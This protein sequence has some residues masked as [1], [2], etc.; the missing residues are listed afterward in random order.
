MFE[1]ALAPA[2]Q[3]TA[4]RDGGASSLHVLILTD[5]DWT[6]PQGGGTGTHL[7]AHVIRWLEWGHRVTIVACGY[8]GAVPYEEV[9]N[10]TIHRMGGRLTVFPRAIWKLCRGL[11]P[12]ADVTLEVINGISYLTPLWW[13]APHIAMVHHIH[14]G[15]YRDELGFI[16]RIAAFLLE[17]A[18]LRFLYRGCRFVTV[19]GVSARDICSHGIPQDHVDVNYNGVELDAFAPGER[20]DEP[21]LLFLGRLKR[22]KQIEYLLS[23]VEQ[24]PGVTLDIAG[25]GDH[26]EELE[27]EI[28]LRGIED[29]VRMHGFVDEATKLHLLQRAWVHATASPREGW[30]LTVMEAAAC[31]TPTVGVAEGGVKESVV[32]GE[33]GLLAT[34][35]EEFVDHTRRLVED[36]DLRERLGQQALERAH[37]FT[38]DASAQRTLSSLRRERKRLAAGVA[39]RSKILTS[40]QSAPS[41]GMAA[42]VAASNVITLLFTLLLARVV[43]W[44]SFGQLAAIVS[45]FMIFAL[46]GA[47]V[48]IAV[49]NEV[50]AALPRGRAALGATVSTWMNSMAVVTAAVAAGAFVLRDELSSLI[51]GPA[52]AAA[53]TLPIG[54]L[55]LM[56]CVQRG[57]LQGLGQTRLVG[58]SLGLEAFGR[59][60]LGALLGAIGLGVTGVFLGSA[61]SMVLAWLSLDFAL[62]RQLGPIS[63]A[64]RLHG[65]RPSLRAVLVGARAP[66]IALALVGLLQNLDVIIAAHAA[67]GTAA[68]SYA[69]SSLV[70]KAFVWCGLAAGLYLV[71]EAARRRRTGTDSRPLL[72]GAVAVVAVAAIPLLLVTWLV[73]KP[74]MTLVFGSGFA[75]ATGALPLLWLAAAAAVCAYLAVQ[76]LIAL[77]RWRF[78]AVLLLAAIVEP[79][80]L[81]RFHSDPTQLAL[82]LVLTQLLLAGALLSI[83]LHRGG[84]LLGL[85]P[86]AGGS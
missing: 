66:L 48:Q 4:S 81:A 32:H 42:A 56:L 49:A 59:I 3:G 57:S 31:G 6:H 76:Y 53:A 41:G 7:H 74:L 73:A 17:T 15:M 67:H 82:T 84:R 20:S 25:D 54:C 24:L 8:P 11:V 58:R 36:H 64:E 50:D 55:W 38:W 79:L 18:P 80:V 16:G 44:D 75:H 65:D 77:E 9:G 45:V 5:R 14:R 40:P 23:V 78:L 2:R 51:G 43:G 22:Y 1:H 86:R 83:S 33:T 72:V 29:R 35:A 37:T 85:A 63:P 46:P 52:L 13:R 30:C 68:S 61:A 26:R 19:S 69:A 70:A 34:S 10:L 21:T 62:R 12:D 47:A 28:K 71:P 27:A 39:P 60:G